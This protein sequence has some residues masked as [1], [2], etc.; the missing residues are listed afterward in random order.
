MNSGC[1]TEDPGD[2]ARTG[3]KAE[4][5]LQQQVRADR[6]MGGLHL[7]HSGLARPKADRDLELGQPQAFTAASQALS[8]CQFDFDESSLIGG[9]PEKVTSVPQGPTSP[10]QSPTLLTSH[11]GFVASPE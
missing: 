8:K 9:Q 5:E 11:G 2:V 4:Q 3:A 7:G 6:S 1:L 10:F